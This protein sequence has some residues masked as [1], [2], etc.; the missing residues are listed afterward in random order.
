MTRLN[1]SVRLGL[2]GALG[3]AVLIGARQL[4][5]ASDHQDTA[6]VELNP[7]Q[8]MTDLY[9]FPAATAGR[10]VLVLNSQ[11]AIS[12]AAAATTSF[13]RNL[14]YQIKVDNTGDAIEDKVIQITFTGSGQSQQVVVRS[15]VVPSVK[16]A[17]NNVLA[18]GGTT[19]TGGLNTTLGSASDIQV[20]AGVRDDPFYIDLEQFFR[21]LPDRKPA[22]GPLAALPSAPTASAF[23]PV[24]Q[25]VNFLTGFN[26]ASIVIE[27]PTVMLTSGGNAKIGV[28]GTISR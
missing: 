18:T 26:V 1:R 5:I 24:G 7:T 9:V 13:D 4:A 16:G 14:L 25:A 6:D 23:R 20:Y 10:T 17:M 28:W 27:L 15:P 19:V 11:P 8:D 2:A 12:P 21:I 22:T 3:V